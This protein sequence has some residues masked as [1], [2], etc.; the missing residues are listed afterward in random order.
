V[1]LALRSRVSRE[2]S[3]TS[4]T[5]SR[6]ALPLDFSKMKTLLRQA[7]LGTLLLAA[8]C[9]APTYSRAQ[10][11][12]K[13]RIVARVAAPYPDIARTMAL[14]GIV[15]VEALVAPDGSVKTVEIKGG[16]PVLA[17][18]AANAVRRWK[19]EAAARESH[20]IVEVKFSPAD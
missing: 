5:F 4:V 16:H 14:E 11:A 19:W 20:E 12:A 6:A 10:D 18:A 15:K 8:L 3:S 1:N 2:D 13:R 7:A 9:L 17:Q